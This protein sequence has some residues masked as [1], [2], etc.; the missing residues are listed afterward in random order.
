MFVEFVLL[1]LMLS[2]ATSCP[3]QEALLPC[4]CESSDTSKYITCSNIDNDLKLSTAVNS[5][6]GMKNIYSFTIE[7]STLNYIPH[8]L[9]EG[10][11]LVELEFLSM[12]LMAFTDTD[13]AFI[14]LENSLEI[15]IV[16]ECDFMNS[17]DW[18]L[19]KNM[20]KL[21]KLDIIGGD[22]MSI[23]DD[24]EEISNLHMKDISFDKNKISYI[25]DYAFSKFA[26]LKFLSLRSNLIEEVK[27]SMLPNPAPELMHLDLS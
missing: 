11:E 20:K 1:F 14:G 4:V 5:L 7:D 21:V 12:S 17:W 24:V 15:L 22:L 26:E 2:A 16:T 10:I 19:L 18:S 3:T 25:Y 9:F 13:V 8:D 27:R 6:R 23:G